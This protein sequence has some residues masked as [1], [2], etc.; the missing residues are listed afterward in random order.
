[1]RNGTLKGVVL[2]ALVACTM[3]VA[4]A[5]ADV[6]VTLNGADPYVGY[7]NILDLGNVFQWGSGWGIADNTATFS[8]NILTLGPNSI[9]DPNSYW[10]T[11]AGGPGCTGNKIMEA[12]TYVEPVG[13]GGQT[14][15]FTGTVISNTLAASHVAKVFIRDFAPDFSSLVEQAIVIPASGTFSISLA[16]I[17]DPAR[18]VQYGFQVKGVDVWVTDRA[19][20]GTVVLG[21]LLPTPTT[22]QSWGALKATYR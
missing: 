13:F 1:M 21:P 18:H 10:Y 7:M 22:T 20:I 14:V 9:G 17:N 6:T 12:N 15:T 5:W 3:C 8:G 4:T 16:T 2:G 19:P 11:P